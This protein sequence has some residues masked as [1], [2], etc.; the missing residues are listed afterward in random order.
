MFLLVPAYPGCPGSKAI[1]RSLLW[2]DGSQQG[3]VG[4]KTLHKQNPPVLNWRCRLTQVDLYNGRKI[5]GCGWM[6]HGWH[7]CCSIIMDSICVSCRSPLVIVGYA[8]LCKIK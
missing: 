4:G 8:V 7:L 6:D 5:G 2:L 1:K 3:L